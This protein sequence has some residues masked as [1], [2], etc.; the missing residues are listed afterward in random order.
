MHTGKPRVSCV[1]LGDGGVGVLL[2]V[3][4]ADEPAI[5]GDTD[6]RDRLRLVTEIK[7]RR[8]DKQRAEPVP[9]ALVFTL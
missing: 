8:I 7:I 9:L 2:G 1:L 4:T 6:A 5:G 3:R